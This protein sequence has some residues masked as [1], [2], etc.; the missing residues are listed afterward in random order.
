M[1]NLFY[2]LINHYRRALISLS[3]LELLRA[4]LIVCVSFLFAKTIVNF[5]VD[6]RLLFFLIFGLVID[7][8]RT[9]QFTKLSLDFQKD[10]RLRLHKNFFSDSEKK[11]GGQLLTIFFDN[12]QS[13]DD[14][15]ILVL[16]NFLSVCILI[17][18]ILLT[19]IFFDKISALIFAVTLPIAPFILYLIGNVLTQKNKAA[20]KSLV[21][22]NSDLK[23]LL[24]AI[25]TLKIFKS[26][27]TAL[28][29]LKISS[30]SAAHF[31]LD[32]LKFAFV[33][34]FALE[35]ITTLSI[36]L[37]AVSI[38]LRLI[39][40]N[41]DFDVALFLLFLAPQYYSPLRRLG[42]AFHSLLKAM[43]SKE[44]IEKSEES[45]KQYFN[46]PLPPIDNNQLIIITGESGSGKTTLIK[47]YK[48][49]IKNEGKVIAYL[50]Q[51]PHIF[52]TSIRNNLS[53]FKPVDDLILIE[54][55]S[56]VGLNFNLNDKI[57]SMSRGQLQRFALARILI[58]IDS[59][60]RIPNSKLF[61]LLDEPTASLDSVSRQL[62]IDVILKISKISQV[63]V[64]THDVNLISNAQKL[65]NLDASA[66]S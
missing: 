27:S 29:K 46:Y 26:T 22:L 25:T 33:S 44:I 2:F 36:A 19:V 49:T 64:A 41:I 28:Y 45:F 13:F 54:A 39:S 18:I 63:I 60:F 17:P 12:V 40:G 30:E 32:V 15:F 5:S 58:Q 42:S 23:E 3:F 7:N 20:L 37:I 21:V 4:L 62:I 52:N 34:T 9:K 35:L 1:K 66:Q 50:P 11:S 16:P 55:L 43:E 24:A 10:I 47:N 38:G 53:I 8:F 31:T 51:F 48:S 6:C 14:L 61:I 56:E 59:A 57:L 65:I